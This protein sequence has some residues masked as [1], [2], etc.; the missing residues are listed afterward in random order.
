MMHKRFKIFIAILCLIILTP[1]LALSSVGVKDDGVTKGIATDINFT[2]DSVV[3]MDGSVAN[4]D[5]DMSTTQTLSGSLTFRTNLLAIG[6]ANGG[7]SEV[8]TGTTTLPVSY[9]MLKCVISTATKTLPDGTE[10]QLLHIYG[11]DRISGTLTII[12]TTSS[13]WES[14]A[15]DA[16]GDSV[17][18]LYLDDTYG[19]IIVGA[20][21]NTT[22][23]GAND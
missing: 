10:G 15:F 2:G 11:Y 9:G 6:Y 18:L 3:T 8:V 14:I 13:G 17:T 20:S 16:N 23:T 7:V 4:V 21:P 22:V 12:A 5:T 1:G 19:W